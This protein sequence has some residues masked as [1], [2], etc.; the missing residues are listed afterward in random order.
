MATYRFLT[1]WALEA[2]IDRVFETIHESERWP[3]W[4][5]GVQSAVEL[6]PGDEDGVGS[7]ARY[8]WRSRLPYELAWRLD[9]PGGEEAELQARLAITCFTW[10]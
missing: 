1:A 4:W 3:E 2:P 10:V 6:E 5:R 7:L 9:Q 8:V